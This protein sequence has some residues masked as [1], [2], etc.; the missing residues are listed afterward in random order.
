VPTLYRRTNLADAILAKLR[1][2]YADR[3]AKTVV[4]YNVAID[5]AQ[6]FGR[7]ICGLQTAQPRRADARGAGRG[8]P[9]T[10]LNDGFSSV[11]VKPSKPLVGG[12]RRSAAERSA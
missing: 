11:R 8:N 12:C 10:I 4:G 3:V 5:E 9:Q 6:S 1:D 2:F 7:T